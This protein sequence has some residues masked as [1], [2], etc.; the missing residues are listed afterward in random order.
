MK[1][2]VPKSS[3]FRMN[4]HCNQLCEGAHVLMEPYRLYQISWVKMWTT[5]RDKDAENP[6]MRQIH[7][8][9]SASAFWCPRLNLPVRVYL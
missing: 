3:K 2:P 4:N 1:A 8:F 9:N 6:I 7:W 5:G